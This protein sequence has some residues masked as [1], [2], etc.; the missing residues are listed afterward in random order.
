MNLKLGMI[1]TGKQCQTHIYYMYIWSINVHIRLKF[2]I[3]MYKISMVWSLRQ[4]IVPHLIC[5]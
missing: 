1:S 4:N 2:E 3:E 5:H